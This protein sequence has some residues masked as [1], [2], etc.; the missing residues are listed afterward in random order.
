MS[1]GWLDESGEPITWKEALL[2]VLGLVALA[3]V[4]VLSVPKAI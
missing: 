3:V 4:V 1:N 2:A